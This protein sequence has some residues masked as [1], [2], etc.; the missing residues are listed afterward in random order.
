M[1]AA[2]KT[3]EARVEAEALRAA[4]HRDNDVKSFAEQTAGRAADRSAIMGALNDLRTD[5]GQRFGEVEHK[6]EAALADVAGIKS[7][8]READAYAQG[9]AD[10]KKP[11]PWLLQI[12]PVI[13][14]ALI[15]SIAA[16]VA[17]DYAQ[18][19]NE[20]HAS[21]T[22]TTSAAWEGKPHR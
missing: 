10:T 2:L 12:A 19:S 22:V 17:H 8:K 18:P 14:T 5:I 6:I 15:A 7:E 1:I 4:E 3:L 13:A 16:W 20:Q 11:N 21:T 9:V